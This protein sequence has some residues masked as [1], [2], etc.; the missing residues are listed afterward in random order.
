MPDMRNEEKVTAES[1]ANQ[2]YRLK[3]G[4]DIIRVVSVFS[5]GGIV[6]AENFVKQQAAQL[7][8]RTLMCYTVL[9]SRT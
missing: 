4:R 5:G 7:D 2:G 1:P 6:P 9:D 8:F 3:I